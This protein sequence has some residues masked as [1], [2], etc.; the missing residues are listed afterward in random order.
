VGYHGIDYNYDP[1]LT[2]TDG[3]NASHENRTL[4]GD[5]QFTAKSSSIVSTSTQIII[6]GGVTFGGKLTIQVPNL[7]QTD[8]HDQTFMTFRSYNG[9]QLETTLEDPDTCVSCSTEGHYT[10]QAFSATVKPCPGSSS[11]AAAIGSSY[12]TPIIVGCVIGG[13]GFLALVAVLLVLFVKPIRDKVF[14]HHNRMVDLT[15][16][17]LQP[18]PTTPPPEK[19]RRRRSTL[20]PNVTE[21]SVYDNHG[22]SGVNP[23]Y[24]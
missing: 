22:K 17:E 20:G 1:T 14:P 19:K 3:V 6:T 15:T 5:V 4:E 7:Q 8:E 23:L 2:L 21:S 18:I 10:D 11:D 24:V 12:Y 9:G 16:E 13:V